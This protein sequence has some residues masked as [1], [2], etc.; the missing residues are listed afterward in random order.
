MNIKMKKLACLAGVVLAYFTIF[1]SGQI[2][3]AHCTERAFVRLQISVEDRS[4]LAGTEFRMKN[5]NQS[6]KSDFELLYKIPECSILN[7]SRK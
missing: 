2:N 5:T 6:I 1:F 3:F 7:L 4:R